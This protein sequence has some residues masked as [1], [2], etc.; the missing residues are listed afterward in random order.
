MLFRSSLDHNLPKFELVG[1]LEEE[2]QFDYC[3]N[4]TSEHGE[5]MDKLL[6]MKKSALVY[7][8]YLKKEKVKATVIVQVDDDKISSKLVIYLQFSYVFKKKC[9]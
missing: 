4:V 6:L 5:V 1:C 3:V 8:G 2:S 9:F 7:K